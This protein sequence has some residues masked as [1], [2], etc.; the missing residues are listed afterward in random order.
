MP[1][2]D[3]LGGAG[4]AGDLDPGGAREEGVGDPL[5]LGAMVAELEHGL[6]A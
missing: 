3:R 1:L 6:T 5:D 2:V 4:L